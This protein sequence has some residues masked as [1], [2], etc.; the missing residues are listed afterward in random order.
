MVEHLQD[1][2]KAAASLDG[3]DRV[4]VTDYNFLLKLFRP[5]QLERYIVDTYGFESGRLFNNNLYCLLVEL[6][7]FIEPT[8]EQICIDYK[9]SRSTAERLIK[10]VSQWCF[11]KHNSPTKIVATDSAKDILALCGVNQKW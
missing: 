10:T 9:V 8:I 11:F 2:L 7:S 3:R 6:A 5:M 4:N 1:Y